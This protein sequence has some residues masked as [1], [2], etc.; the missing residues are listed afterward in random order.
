[1]GWGGFW[2]EAGTVKVTAVAGDCC[3]VQVQ[4]RSADHIGGQ[5]G[6]EPGPG[7]ED[8]GIAPR[9]P[10]PPLGLVESYLSL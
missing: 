10:P 8:T 1:M 6:K 5:V 2:L 9:P 4:L 7:S 3:S